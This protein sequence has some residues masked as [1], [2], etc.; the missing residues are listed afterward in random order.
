MAEKIDSLRRQTVTRHE[1]RLLVSNL[2]D[3][4]EAIYNHIIKSGAKA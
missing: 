4:V 2:H 1:F 3:R